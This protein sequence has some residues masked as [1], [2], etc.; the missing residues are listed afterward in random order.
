[1]WFGWTPPPAGAGLCRHCA[2]S[3]VAKE[4]R[5]AAGSRFTAG[6]LVARLVD[7]H[8]SAA[9]CRGSGS[10]GKRSA[11]GSRL[12]ESGSVYLRPEFADAIDQTSYDLSVYHID[13]D[14]HSPQP[15]R[16]SRRLSQAAESVGQ[17]FIHSP[18]LLRK[19]RWIQPPT[20]SCPKRGLPALRTPHP[21]RR[22]SRYPRPDRVRG[23]IKRCDW[24]LLFEFELYPSEWSFVFVG[25]KSPILTSMI[26]SSGISDLPN[27]HFLGGKP[28]AAWGCYPQHFDVCTMPYG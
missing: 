19:K 18:A 3:C 6:V 26:Y 17:V 27:V 23:L 25:P 14:I 13:D 24:E 22:P 12:Y 8:G 10:S 9:S 21:S 2:R 20:N 1:M 15:K 5:N 7:R 4:A 28:R 16:K 11:A